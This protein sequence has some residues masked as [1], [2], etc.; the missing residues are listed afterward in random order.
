M[1]PSAGICLAKSPQ[2]HHRSVASVLRLKTA[3][4]G[5]RLRPPAPRVLIAFYRMST[6]T[7]TF[8]LA[9]VQRLRRAAVCAAK[10]LDDGPECWHKSPVD[11]C[12]VLAAFPALRLLPG[13]TLRAYASREG[14][15]GNAFVY[16]T[17]IDAPFP[18]VQTPA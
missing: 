16:A 18:R 7:T 8:T 9:M 12:A 17:P 3:R 10:F 2:R 14:G 6:S 11:P 15:N 4:R 5:S 13:I 1:R